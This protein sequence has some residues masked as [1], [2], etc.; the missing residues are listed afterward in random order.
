LLKFKDAHIAA[1]IGTINAESVI[2]HLGAKKGVLKDW[3]TESKL[4]KIKI[5]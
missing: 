3:P 4:R 2:Q 1:R 5:V